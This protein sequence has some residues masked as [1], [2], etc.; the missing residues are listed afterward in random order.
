[1]KNHRKTIGIVLLFLIGLSILLYPTISDRWN[2]YRA[3]QLISSYDTAVATGKNQDY[4]KMLAEASDYNVK[5]THEIIPDA[6]SIRDGV[7]D[8]TYESLLN[9]MGDGMM[10]YVEIPAIKVKSPLYHYTTEEVLKK[11]IGH[12]FGSSLPVGGKNTHAV[13]SAHRGLPSAKLFTDLDLVEK[14]DVFYVHVLDE[15]LAYKVDQILVVKPEETE[16]LGIEEDKDYVTLVTCTPYAVNSHRILVRGHRIPYD[17]EL[18]KELVQ[19][20]SGQKTPDWMPQVICVLIGCMIA[21]GVAAFINRKELMGKRK[22]KA[23]NEETADEEKSGEESEE[24]RD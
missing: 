4:S 14:G 19:N 12:L 24:K 5:L 1:M 18:H 17:G 2:E 21:A 22:S 20:V 13:V 6:F 8:K 15:I 7:E 11:G 16:A 9:P 10:G 23:K 3:Q